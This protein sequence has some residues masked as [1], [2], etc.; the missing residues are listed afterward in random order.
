MCEINFLCVHQKHRSKNLAAQLIA[1]VTRRVN[2]RNK[3]QAVTYHHYVDLHLWYSPPDALLPD[4]LLPSL[5][6]P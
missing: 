6:E 5:L 4:H 1:E 2:L 3:W